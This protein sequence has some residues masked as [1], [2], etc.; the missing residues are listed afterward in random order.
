M[1]LESICTKHR[2][3]E[4]WELDCGTPSKW[5]STGRYMWKWR[6]TNYTRKAPRGTWKGNQHDHTKGQSANHH[7]GQLGSK[8]ELHIVQIIWLIEHEQINLNLKYKLMV[9][10]DNVYTYTYTNIYVR[11]HLQDIKNPYIHNYIYIYNYICTCTGQDLPTTSRLEA[12]D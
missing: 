8:T 10:E 3:L 4:E 6:T 2:V 5:P 12:K 7:K 11:V 9:K 1:N